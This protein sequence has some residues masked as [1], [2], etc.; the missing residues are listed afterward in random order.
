LAVARGWQWRGAAA[1]AAYVA[2]AAGDSTLCARLYELLAPYD[3]GL[4]ITGGGANVMGPVGLYLGSLASCCGRWEAAEAHLEDALTTAERMEGRPAVAW[5]QFQLAQVLLPRGDHGDRDRARRLLRSAAEDADR[6]QMTIHAERARAVL[7]TTEPPGNVFRREGDVWL[8]SFEGTTVRLPDAKGLHDI[9]R[10]LATP[11]LEVSASELV[12]LQA[13][14]SDPVLDD[15]ARHAYRQRLAELDKTIADADR[16]Q[17]LERAARARVEKD[18][19][20]DALSAAYGLGGR[21]RRVSDAAERA[22]KSATARIRDTLSRIHARHPSLG[23]HLS[24][25]ITT[26]TRCCYQP[27]E[28]TRWRL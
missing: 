1:T 20:V 28:L 11:G 21:P 13:T 8:L 23:E 22:R 18:A 7:R 2:G 15:R 9:A 26:G 4:V 6:L 14:E 16:D 12:G 27:A 24:A 19:L 25:S 10:L 3:H 5:T 17:D